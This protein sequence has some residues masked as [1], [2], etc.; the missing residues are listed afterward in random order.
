MLS[1]WCDVQMSVWCFEYRY[2]TPFVQTDRREGKLR[3]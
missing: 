3:G 1:V 2:I